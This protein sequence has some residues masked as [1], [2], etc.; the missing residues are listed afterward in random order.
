MLTFILI[1]IV[2]YILINILKDNLKKKYKKI[3]YIG[4]FQYSYLHE[5]KFSNE[6]YNNILYILDIFFQSF[7]FNPI[8][9]LNRKMVRIK[10]E[11]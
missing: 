10:K 2:K 3:K 6:S 11:C 4:F 9:N 8:E 1:D 7:N 5:Y